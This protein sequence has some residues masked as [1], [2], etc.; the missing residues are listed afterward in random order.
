MIQISLT[1]FTTP[2]RFQGHFEFCPTSSVEGCVSMLLEGHVE[3]FALCRKWDDKEVL[4]VFG[5]RYA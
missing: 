2:V 5:D 4:F 3:I 1:P